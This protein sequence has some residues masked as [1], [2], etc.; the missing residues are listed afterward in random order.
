M[1]REIKPAAEI[2]SEMVT[3]AVARLKGGAA[4]VEE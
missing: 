2:I 1:V 4:W 3:D